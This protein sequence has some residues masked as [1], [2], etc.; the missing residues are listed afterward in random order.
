MQT[1][2]QGAASAS[3]VEALKSQVST[4]QNLVYAT[5]GLVVVTL[6]VSGIG[7]ARKK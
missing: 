7:L 5:L 3:D 6:I 1:T 2:L 4:L